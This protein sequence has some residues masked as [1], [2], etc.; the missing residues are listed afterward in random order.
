[1]FLDVCVY[2]SV[3]A[4]IPPL[5]FETRWNSTFIMLQSAIKMKSIITRMKDRDK[6]FPDIPDEEEWRRAEILCTVLKPFYECKL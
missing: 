3:K 2:E 5:D 4:I 6:T 1:M